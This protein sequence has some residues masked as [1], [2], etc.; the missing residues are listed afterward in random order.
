MNMHD[1]RFKYIY[2]HNSVNNIV[3]SHI[4]F[5]KT[6][7]YHVIYLIGLYFPTYFHDLYILH[8]LIKLNNTNNFILCL[9]LSEACY[10][11]P[12]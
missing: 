8:Q 4:S 3:N 2:L 11:Q 1:Y 10:S 7:K 6:L 9:V 5:I 12:I